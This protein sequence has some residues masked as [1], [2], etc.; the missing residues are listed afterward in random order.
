FW[1]LKKTNSSGPFERDLESFERLLVY[2]N[3]F[4][5]YSNRLSPKVFYSNTSKVYSN[6]FSVMF[7][8]RIQFDLYSNKHL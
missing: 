8:I 4:I 1:Y 5:F 7:S 2:S 6:T 3:R